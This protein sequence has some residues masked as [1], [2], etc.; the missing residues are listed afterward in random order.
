MTRATS[1]YLN[2]AHWP[3]AIARLRAENVRLFEA[4]KLL[5]MERDRLLARVAELERALDDLMPREAS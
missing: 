1:A 4:N 2:H 5:C 3:D